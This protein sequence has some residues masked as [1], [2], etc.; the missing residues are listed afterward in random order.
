MTKS[1]LGIKDFADKSNNI[2]QYKL[3]SALASIYNQIIVFRFFK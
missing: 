3:P 2:V 1:G